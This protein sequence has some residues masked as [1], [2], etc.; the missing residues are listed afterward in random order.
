[1]VGTEIVDMGSNFAA[2]AAAAVVVV[3]EVEVG[4]VAE[5]NLRGSV[6]AVSEGTAGKYPVDMAAGNLSIM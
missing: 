4:V 5:C 3:V 6:V 1:M 2:A